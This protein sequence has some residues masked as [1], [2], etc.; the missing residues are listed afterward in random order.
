MNKKELEIRLQELKGFSDPD[1]EIEQYRTPPWLAASVVW[2]AHMEGLVEGC[3]VYD[4]G[5]G[6][7]VLGL[8]AKLLGAFEVVC[9][10]KDPHAVD[11][12]KENA[13]KLDLDIVFKCC[14]IADLDGQ[15]DLVLQN[16]PFGSQKKGSDRPFIRKSLQLASVVYSFHLSKTDRFVRNYVESCGGEV[17]DSETVSF[18]L[19]KSMPWHQSELE[20]IK[21]N[22]YKFKSR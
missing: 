14:D 2:K 8:G 13:R 10:D 12:A 22:L 6:T 18:P 4:L 15:A 20:E 3:R 19:E 16:P 7:G 1:P 21:V 17:V 5:C 9:V 11:I